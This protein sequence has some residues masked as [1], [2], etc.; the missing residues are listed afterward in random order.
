MHN[1]YDIHR[2]NQREDALHEDRMRGEL[3]AELRATEE[4]LRDAP[5]PTA[6]ER[7]LLHY[8]RVLLRVHAGESLRH[9]AGVMGAALLPKDGA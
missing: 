1:L 4:L 3:L 7:Q 6:N 2:M 9:V 5:Q 8:A